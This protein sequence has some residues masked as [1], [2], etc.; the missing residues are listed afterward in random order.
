MLIR[1]KNEW[2]TENLG[3]FFK[4][5]Y[6]KFLLPCFSKHQ[7]NIRLTSRVMNFSDKAKHNM[8]CFNTHANGICDKISTA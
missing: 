8:A 1:L 3:Q 5:A 2:T 7:M 4:R 6:C